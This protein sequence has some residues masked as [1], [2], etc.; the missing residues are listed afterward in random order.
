MLKSKNN[1][2]GLDV[3]LEWT[4]TFCL[5]YLT[6]TSNQVYLKQSTRSVELHFFL[7]FFLL[8]SL[9]VFIQKIMLSTF[10]VLMHFSKTK[11]INSMRNR[12]C[13]W[14]SSYKCTER[15]E[16]VF[17][18]PIPFHLGLFLAAK[19]AQKSTHQFVCLSVS[20]TSLISLLEMHQE[21]KGV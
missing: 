12:L 21:F 4:Q 18:Y 13:I 11:Q 10:L 5:C 19:A 9:S 8:L 1:Y 7:F 6:P 17:L 16:I 20:H 14:T 3:L 2:Q 15:A